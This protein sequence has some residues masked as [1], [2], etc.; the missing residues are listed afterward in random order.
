MAATAAEQLQSLSELVVLC[1]QLYEGTDLGQ[2]VQAEKVLVELIE[3]PECLSKCQL[4]LEQG[5]TS[6][7]WLLA[8]TCLAKLVSRVNP[9]P[10]EQRIDISK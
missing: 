7:A 10:I 8:A 6:Y 1:T 5:T 9:L 3:S 4:L 2:W